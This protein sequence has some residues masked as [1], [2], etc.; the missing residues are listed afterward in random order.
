MREIVS[1]RLN[2]LVDPSLHLWGWEVGVYLFAGGLVAGFMVVAGYLLFRGAHRDA[3]RRSSLRWIPG[4]AI[5]VLTLGMFALFLDL[6]YKLHV[7]RFYTAFEISSPMSWGSWI[8]VLVYPVLFATML[9]HPPQ[10]LAARFRFVERRRACLLSHER[11][12]RALAWWNI[13]LGI[14]L[15]TY[16]GILLGA[17]GARPFWNSSFLGILFLVSGVSTA[18]AVVHLAT[19]N[20]G[21]RELAMRAD[22][23]LIAVELL[24]LVLFLIG[25]STSTDVHRDALALVMGGPFT[26]S[27]WVLVVVLGLLVPLLIYSLVIAKKSRHLAVA[28]LLVL[29]GGLVLRFVFV[30]AGQASTWLPY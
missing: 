30:A 12:V 19:R 5:A 8:L 17:L 2:P 14:A 3:E 16:T 4:A 22:A 29:A 26:A 6:E 7:F 9:L 15:G 25:L 27:F 1:T 10:W 24:L 21:E 13:G 11:R 18:L 28:P 23:A 20:A